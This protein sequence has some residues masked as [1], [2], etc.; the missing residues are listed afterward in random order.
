M[1]YWFY[2]EVLNCP[3]F[4]AMFDSKTSWTATLLKAEPIGFPETSVTNYKS[5]LHNIPEERRSLIYS[6]IHKNFSNLSNDCNKYELL[7]TLVPM[8]NLVAELIIL[9]TGVR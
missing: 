6:S 2:L 8:V 4:L 9:I 7:V 5:M 3:K 1:I